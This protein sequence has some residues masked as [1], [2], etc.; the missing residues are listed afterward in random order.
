MLKKPKGSLLSDL[1]ALFSFFVFFRK[2]FKVSRVPLHFFKFCN[3]MDVKKSQRAPFT[4]F[5][6]VRFFKMNIFC[7]KIMSSQAQYAMS[8]FF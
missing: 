4:V 2:F 3:R 7:L 1:L 8:D 5:G 6:I